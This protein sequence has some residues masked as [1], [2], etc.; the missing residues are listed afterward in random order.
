MPKR[1]PNRALPRGPH[2]LSR[3]EVERSQ[4]ERLMLAMAEVVA[5]KGFA[6]VAVADVLAR[7]GVSRAT[8]YAQFKDKE[9][10]FRATYEVA[11]QHI[12]KVM[13]M[14]I[15]ALAA[16]APE[17]GAH[18][19]PME[20]LE[21]ILTVYLDT[22]IGQPTFARTFLVEVYAAGP[23][24]VKQR[25][26]SQELFVDIICETHRGESGLLGT[27]PEQ[28]FAAEAI[29]NAV[30]AMMTNLIAIGDFQRIRELK[31]P[32]MNF[33]RELTSASQA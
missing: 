1:A 24:A 14:G 7:A 22:L 18:L 15:A 27:K 31:E 6:N 2:G 17:Q 9:D 12:G 4:R 28:R 20:K 11:A 10:C 33:V 19:T 29:V 30:S 32:M 13:G 3:E 26:A 16:T 5:E 8:F 25:L 21:R 23:E